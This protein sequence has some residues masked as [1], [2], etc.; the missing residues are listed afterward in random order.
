MEFHMWPFCVSQN[1]C[2]KGL[3][4]RTQHTHKDTQNKAGLAWA[5]AKFG[6]TMQ[7]NL[8]L[9]LVCCACSWNAS[10]TTGLGS[11]HPNYG[12]DIEVTASSI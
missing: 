4:M 9:S 5:V 6:K 2:H 11:R 3:E 12:N 1:L 7:T 8:L 10:T